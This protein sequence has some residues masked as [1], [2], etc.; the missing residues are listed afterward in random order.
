MDSQK[1]PQTYKIPEN[2]DELCQL[3]RAYDKLVDHIDHIITEVCGHCAGACVESW[4]PNEHAG[5]G[6]V[7]VSYTK[8]WH[9][10]TDWF[11]EE[12]PAKY[13]WMS[14]DEILADCRRIEEEKE[15]LEHAR[16]KQ[17]LAAQEQ[18]QYQ[19]YLRLK[20]VYEGTEA[21]DGLPEK[22]PNL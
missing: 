4:S 20:E 16:Q 14:D 5:E 11:G 2:F 12:F 15:A 21:V 8:T 10:E 7:G 1:N 18:K 13:L 17:E 9:G 22:S 6:T 3:S 19:T